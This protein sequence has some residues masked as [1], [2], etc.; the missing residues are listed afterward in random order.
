MI[1]IINNKSRSSL[2]EGRSHQMGFA[3]LK[4]VKD[5]T[6]ETIQPISPC[7]DYLNDVIFAEHT[8]KSIS[9]YGCNLKGKQDIFDKN[10]GYI[11]ISICPY[12]YK[13]SY[14][15]T[16]YLK[17]VE[18][19]KE[20]HKNLELFINQIEEYFNLDSFNNTTIVEVSD[21]LYFI[22]VP[23][24]W[25]MSTYMI[26][27]YSLLLRVGQFYQDT[28][29]DPI[30]WLE[31]FNAF[32]DDVSLVKQ[33]LPKLKNIIKYGPLPQDFSNLRGDSSTHNLGIV[34]YNLDYSQLINKNNV[35]SKE[36]Q[37]A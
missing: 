19:L 37:T 33:S 16:T 15:T 20:N 23:I 24:I 8:N 13:N 25:T 29:K 18:R 31:K 2:S 10:F 1:Q 17:D 12:K 35:N 14:N 27:L 5:E 6:F 21:N 30:E 34:S 26:S 22:E 3:F 9:A 28:T 11:A 4:K 36:V 32:I 7:K